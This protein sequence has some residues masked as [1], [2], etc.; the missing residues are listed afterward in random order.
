MPTITSMAIT[1]ETQRRV[2]R[3]RIGVT[4]PTTIDRGTIEAAM[5]DAITTA[6]GGAGGT[7]DLLQLGLAANPNWAAHGPL[8]RVTNTPLDPDPP[9]G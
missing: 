7:V 9:P 5:V 2:L 4:W 1:T 8:D 3:A 6:V